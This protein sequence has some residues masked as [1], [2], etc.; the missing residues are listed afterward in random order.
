MI[1]NVRFMNS[2]DA[3]DGHEVLQGP[4]ARIVPILMQ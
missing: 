3:I 4:L 1:G 2:M